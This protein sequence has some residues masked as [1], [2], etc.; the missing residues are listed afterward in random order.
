MLETNRNHTTID[1][2]SPDHPSFAQLSDEAVVNMAQK[3]DKWAEEEI[4][5]RYHPLIRSKAHRYF[6]IGAD[7]EDLYQEGMIGLY[8]AMRDYRAERESAFR[9]F[10]ELCI[11]RQMISA[12]KS[13]TRKKHGPLNSYISLNKPMFEEEGEHSLMDMLQADPIYDPEYASILQEGN[14]NVKQQIE[15]IL[16]TFERQVLEQYLAGKS[17]HEI[18]TDLNRNDKAIDN[19]LQRIKR[20][21]ENQ[22]V[23][24]EK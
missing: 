13:A 8:K 10:A 12:I 1:P 23:L 21:I 24:E 9:S 11:K 3:G 16:S 22:F 14:Q 18:A 5:K 17:Y 2:N 15:T 4:F 19:A 6:L 7:R 20:K